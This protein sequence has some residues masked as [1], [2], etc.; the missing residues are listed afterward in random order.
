[1]LLFLPSNNTSKTNKL[2]L[3]TADESGVCINK[4]IFEAD[5]GLPSLLSFFAVQNSQGQVSEVAKVVPPIL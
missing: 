2:F 4:E 3:D 1:M 5:S